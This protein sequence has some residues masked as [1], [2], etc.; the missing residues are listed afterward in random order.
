MNDVPNLVTDELPA[1]DPPDQQ[2]IQQLCNDVI[3]IIW[4]E[5]GLGTNRPTR[6]EQVIEQPLSR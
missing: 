2:P 1:I 5:V 3:P 4:Y 6:Q